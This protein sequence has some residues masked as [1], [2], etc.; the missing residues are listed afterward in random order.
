MNTLTLVFIVSSPS[1]W[2]K[3]KGKK[4][5]LKLKK[6]R[7]QNFGPPH[8]VLFLTAIGEKKK[9]ETLK[10]STAGF[11]RTSLDVL[12]VPVHTLIIYDGWL[13]TIASLLF[14][15]SLAV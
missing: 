6:K 13:C 3:K 9:N 12:S 10:L 14:F 8:A 7:E 15:E 1:F 4:K 5:T 2:D 11:L